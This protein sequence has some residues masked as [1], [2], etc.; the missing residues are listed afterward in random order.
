MGVKGGAHPA[1]GGPRHAAEQTVEAAARMIVQS[2]RGPPAEIKANVIKGALVSAEAELEAAQAF[3]GRRGTTE[4]EGSAAVLATGLDAPPHDQ[5][6]APQV[7]VA[8][9]RGA[10]LEERGGTEVEEKRGGDGVALVA[11]DGHKPLAGGEQMPLQVG[12]ETS[13][14]RRNAQA[15]AGAAMERIV[16]ADVLELGTHGDGHP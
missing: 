14:L 16:G 5:V 8:E 11:G 3:V 10:K 1:G 7:L 2:D 12:K 15:L 4:I 9:V 6:A 13:W